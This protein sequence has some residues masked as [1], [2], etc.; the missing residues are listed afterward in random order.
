[1]L[2]ERGDFL[3]VSDLARGRLLPGGHPARIRLCQLPL[4]LRGPMKRTLPPRVVGTKPP[5]AEPW[6]PFVAAMRRLPGWSGWKRRGRLRN[7]AS[8]QRL[9]RAEREREM[10]N[11]ER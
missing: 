9:E 5:P 3:V 1:M 10:P 8:A 2:E 7:G 11:Q 4:A 6:K